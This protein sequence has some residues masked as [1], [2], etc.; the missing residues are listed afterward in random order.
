VIERAFRWI[1]VIAALFLF[2]CSEEQPVVTHVGLPDPES[3]GAKL[4]KD[5]C[6]HCHAPPSPAS[7]VAKEWPNI[8]ARMNDRRAMLALKVY[9]DD[10]RIIM[11]DYLQKNSGQP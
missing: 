7:H 5:Y 11:L 3:T 1:L 8:M 10:E 9:T 6:S 2:G 4:V